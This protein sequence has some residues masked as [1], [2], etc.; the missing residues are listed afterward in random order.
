MKREIF[1]EYDIRGIVGED[2]DMADVEILGRSYG[3]YLR[4]HGGER[5]VIGR[6]CRISSPPIREALAAGLAESGV[7]VTDVG[8]CPTPLFYFA[9]RHLEADGGLMITASHNPPEYNGFKVCLGPDTIFGEEIQNFRRLLEKGAFVSGKGSLDSCDIITPY[10]EYIVDNISLARPVKVAVDAGNG[11]GGV[12]AGPI[13]RRLGCEIHELFFEMDGRF[14]NHE[15]D[16]T[17]PDNMATLADTVVREGL[18]LGIGFDGDTDRI[19]VVDERGRLLYGDMLMVIFARD[20]LKDHPGATI[21]GEVKCSKNMYD[22]IK[23]HGGNPIMWKTGHSLIKRKLR[24]EKALLAGEMSGHL[25]FAHR[26]FGYDD[27]IYAA[28]RLLEILSR[29]DEPLSGYLS[30]LPVTY[31]TPEIRVHCAEDKK[32]QLVNMVREELR[33]GHEIIDVDGVRVLFSDGWG[34]LRASNTGP[35]LVLRYEALSEAR[36]REIRTLLETT[37]EAMKRKL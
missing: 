16:P 17:V 27:A 7:H 1:R 32:F 22:D 8:I 23:A 11:T 13:L 4:S 29:R 24:E 20:I 28:C 34:L 19:G 30:D 14:P 26:Y 31:N 12:V 2:F 21:I 10:T 35:I 3:T 25:F 5:A 37:L 9:L 18:E 15:P 36:L 6:D 33:K